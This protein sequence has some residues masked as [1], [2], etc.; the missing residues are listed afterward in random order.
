M[1]TEPSPAHLPARPRAGPARSHERP[2]GTAARRARGRAATPRRRRRRARAAARPSAIACERGKSK[3]PGY[4]REH[5]SPRIASLN[6]G[7]SR[8]SCKLSCRSAAESD[9]EREVL[10]AVPTENVS[11]DAQQVEGGGTLVRAA[12]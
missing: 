12:A 10:R 6:I 9:R 3:V 7:R 5:V 11:E 2:A 1:T 4:Q 8:Q